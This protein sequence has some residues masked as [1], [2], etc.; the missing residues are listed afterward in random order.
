MS[1]HDQLHK[2]KIVTWLNDAWILENEQIPILE[3][4]AKDAADYPNMHDRIEQHIEETRRHA[5]LVRQCVGRL[6]GDVSK[7]KGEMGSV[8]GK[9]KSIA[10]GLFH[11]ELL[12]N[13]LAGYATEHFE[14]ACYR[15]LIAACEHNGEQEIAETCRLI[16]HDEEEMASWLEQSIPTVTEEILHPRQAQESERRRAVG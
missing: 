1:T 5:D 16:L 15:S 7:L 11:D 3:N 13:T 14:I 2:D 9:I 6:G 8:L 12:K 10:T 4:H